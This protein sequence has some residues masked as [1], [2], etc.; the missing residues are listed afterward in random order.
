M[1]PDEVIQTKRLALA[2]RLLEVVQSEAWQRVMVPYLED[3]KSVMVEAMAS[4][5][6]ALQLMRYAGSVQT[7]HKLIHLEQQVKNVI[8]EGAEKKMS[9]FRN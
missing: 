9:Q 1:T 7:F 5:T 3:E 8:A 4:Q 2:H 6:E